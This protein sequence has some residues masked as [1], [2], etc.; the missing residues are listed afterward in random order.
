MCMLCSLYY[1]SIH[2]SIPQKAV[3]YKVNK[4]SYLNP[5]EVEVINFKCQNDLYVE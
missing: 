1:C 2:I 5:S 4:L 3:K